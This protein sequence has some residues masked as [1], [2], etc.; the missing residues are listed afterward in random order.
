MELLQ[1]QL[2]AVAKA[3][4]VR[5]MLNSQILSIEEV[6]RDTGL[7]PALC[8]RAEQLSSLCLGYG[9]GVSYD[10]VP[11]ARMGKR[12]IFDEVTP[13]L[14]RIMCIVDVIY[15]LMKSSG[16]RDYVSLDE[17]MYD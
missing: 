13:N 2:I 7:L 12:V 3:M 4:K 6:F 17:L 15:E 9:L 8:K 1:E 11:E 14:I 5:F 10:D 16:S